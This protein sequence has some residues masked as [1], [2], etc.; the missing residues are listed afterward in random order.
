MAK[1]YLT[2]PL[3]YVNSKL[4]VGHT[5]TTL[6]SD[7][8]IRYKKAMGFDTFF[9][10]G[11]DEH[12]QKIFEAAREKNITPQQLADENVSYF[13]ELWKLLNVKYDKFIRTTDEYHE[14]RVRDV[15]QKLYNKGDIYKG[16]YEAYHCIPCESFWNEKQLTDGKCPTCGGEV[17]WEEQENYFFKISKYKDIIR[18]KLKSDPNLIR[19]RIRYNEIMGKLDDSMDDKSISRSHF[20][21]GVRLPF[22]DSQVCYV[23]FDAIL[24]YI[25]AIGYS[26]DMEMFNRYWPADIHVIGK[27]ILWFHTLFWFSILE[28]LD[29]PLPTVYAHGYWL[30]K[31]GKMSKRSGVVVDPFELV[32]KYGIDPL[33]FFLLSELSEGS[34]TEFSEER[35]VGKFNTEL[36]NI[37]SNTLHRTLTMVEK[38]LDGSL[39]YIIENTDMEDKLIAEYEKRREEYIRNFDNF[40]LPQAIDAVMDFLRYINGYIN[41]AAPFKSGKDDKNRTAAILYTVLEAV[42][43]V[44]LMLY[45]IIPDTA[46]KIL[47]RLNCKNKIDLKKDLEWGRLDKKSIYKKDEPIFMRLK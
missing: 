8:V 41:D 23:W 37:V 44:S 15:L 26:D 32:D 9:L 28:A 25:T 35:L 36:V 10:T 30:L 19:P 1:F 42:R 45:P 3:Y 27:D 24:N 40:K 16:K 47:E 12:G 38:Y 17:K 13:K 43:N 20:D 14:K 4:H 7:A 46:N 29:I 5:Y 34:D 22:D 6:F 39:D 11:S 18:E 31:G 2:T 21:W 33:R